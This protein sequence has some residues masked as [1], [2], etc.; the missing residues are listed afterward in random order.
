MA[1]VDC[2]ERYLFN[3]NAYKDWYGVDPLSIRG[4]TIRSVVG[5]RN[6][7][8]LKPFIERVLA[9]EPIL[10]EESLITA[11]GPRYV[12]GSYSPDRAEDGTIR[13]FFVLVSDISERHR[14]ELRLKESEARFAGAFQ[15]AGIGMAIVSPEGRILQVNPAL[16]IMLGYTEAEFD[17]LSF[18][19]ITHPDDLAAD[20][21]SFKD[22][23]AGTRVAY[24]MEKRYIHKDRHEIHAI[25]N[26]SLVRDFDG[27]PLHVVAQVQNITDR[28][29]AEDRLFR[30]H[31]LSQVTLRSI[32]DAVITT[33]V[34]GAVTSLN[35]AAENMIG[36]LS[37]EAKGRP[38]HE[39]F[40][41]VSRNDDAIFSFPRPQEIEE[42]RFVL[43]GS[44]WQAANTMLV[45]RDGVAIP[46]EET[47]A[48]IRDR[49]G[50]VVGHVLVFHDVT[51]QRTLTAQMAY[52]AHHDTLTDL[53]NRILFKTRLEQAIAQTRHSGASVAVLF[54]DLDRLKLTND[55]LGHGAGDQL[56][57]EAASRLRA[58]VRDSDMVS[59]WAGDEFGILLPNVTDASVVATVAQ[60]A[61][62]SIAE[63]F[64]LAGVDQPVNVGI[65]FGISLYPH[66]G[67]DSDTLMQAADVA[68]YEVKRNGRGSYQFFSRGMND[69]A[70]ERTRIEAMLRQAVRTESF[71]LH[72]QPRMDLSS[73]KAVG[74]EALVR[75]R[76]RDELIAPSRFIR[77]AEET[78]LIM[79]IGWWVIERVCQ[80]LKSWAGTDLGGLTVALNVSPVQA[81]R[82]DFYPSLLA[83][84]AKYGV[85]PSQIELEITE[86]TLVEPGPSITACM[87]LLK[88]A[89][90]AMSLDD[91]GT[92]YS[93]FSY[94]NRLPIDTLKIDRSFIHD[95]ASPQGAVVVD[96]MLALGK[97]LGKKVVAEGVETQEQLD[98]L[99]DKGCEEAQ[100]Y[101][102]CPPLAPDELAT[103]LQV[104]ALL[105]S[106]ASSMDA[107][108]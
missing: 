35:P 57:K 82:E 94:L 62:T 59:R 28:K 60:R 44:G 1:Y 99:M 67:R 25:L 49:L 64:H 107:G 24:T 43:H 70:R 7:T 46:I 22:M 65:S 104:R 33:D 14:L 36:W 85:H 84:T 96:A 38:L 40:T 39:L 93:S 32:G 37:E 76:N 45:R 41:I 50:E 23:L 78:G 9:G 71:E 95:V 54:G 69:R 29:I 63:A 66:D 97:A 92:G 8:R 102:F 51:K 72:Y 47:A 12:Q 15:S 10:Y 52:L 30:E 34:K 77:I 105:Q 17:T 103:T 87:N 26:V 91:F 48:P 11:T 4:Q 19:D 83:M 79:P 27:A 73:R 3:N 16:C 61:I 2:D 101:F 5:D 56:L 6:Y 68:L 88:D 31:E 18:Q 89:G 42:E 75:L 20:L 100:G 53:P 90:F 13:G 81:R 106:R 108:S 98:W 21:R 80:Q 55:T 74:V 86:S 58:C